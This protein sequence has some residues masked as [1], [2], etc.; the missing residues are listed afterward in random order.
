MK[1]QVICTVQVRYTQ[2]VSQTSKI[3]KTQARLEGDRQF[4]D[5]PQQLHMVSSML[6]TITHADY[7]GTYYVLLVVPTYINK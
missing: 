7:M 3:P 5:N 2:V 4:V 1:Q 6:T